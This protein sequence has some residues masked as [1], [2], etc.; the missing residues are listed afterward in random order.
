MS[1][2]ALV[3][4]EQCMIRKR[5]VC[6]VGGNWRGVRVWTYHYALPYPNH[7]HLRESEVK[8]ISVTTKQ[9]SDPLV[10][11]AFDLCQNLCQNLSRRIITH[12]GA[13]AAKLGEDYMPFTHSVERCIA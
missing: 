8:I 7:L 6:W 11:C 4:E 13:H 10:F 5:G 2:S 3:R 9:R 12:H 1:W